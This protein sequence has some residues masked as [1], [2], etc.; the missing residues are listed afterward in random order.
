MYLK[1]I[2]GLIKKTCVKTQQEF[3]SPRIEIIKVRLANFKVL[4]KSKM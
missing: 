2:F 4:K 1:L 3:F